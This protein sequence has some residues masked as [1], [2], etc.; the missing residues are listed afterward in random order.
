V[1]TERTLIYEALVAFVMAGLIYLAYS[2]GGFLGLGVLGLLTAGIAFQADLDKTAPS[3]I[4]PILPMQ[5]PADRRDELSLRQEAEFQATPILVG[6]LLGLALNIIG[7]GFS[8]F[9]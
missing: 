3:W 8:F 9:L 7:F 4:N 5:N 6:K 1:T 2:V